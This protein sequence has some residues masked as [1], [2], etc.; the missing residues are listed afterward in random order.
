[1]S[2][3]AA[4]V[5]ALLEERKV[6]YEVLH[7]QRDYT[8]LETAAHTHTPGRRFAKAVI[9]RIAGEPAMAVLPSHHHVD[10]ERFS[11]AIGGKPV[12][13]APEEDVEV[14]FPDC[15][16]GAVPIFGNLYGL[17][18]YV[19]PELAEREF[20][21]SVAGSHAE[22]IRLRYAD[23]ARLAEPKPVELSRV[24]SGNPESDAPERG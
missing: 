5:R 14:L 3:I 24:H 10:P 13:L 23:F 6:E 7:H 16:P 21:T 18:V 19:S 17:P 4:R 20:L 15:E 11:S 2:E 9:V 12:E 1:M 22:A 8:A